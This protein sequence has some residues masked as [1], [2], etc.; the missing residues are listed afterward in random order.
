LRWP[1][2][3][4]ETAYEKKPP[5]PYDKF[6]ALGYFVAE[7]VPYA[8]VW[9][10]YLWPSFV[11]LHS[12]AWFVCAA[13][14]TTFLLVCLFAA[15]Q[16]LHIMYPFYSMT[17]ELVFTALGVVSKQALVWITLYGFVHSS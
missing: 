8:I 10:L 9:G 12:P 6:V 11:R 4:T 13:V 14:V 3:R 1:A 7:L 15:L 16:L 17:H 2:R 5:G